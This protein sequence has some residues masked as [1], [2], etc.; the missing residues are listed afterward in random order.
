MDKHKYEIT[1]TG[2]RGAVSGE[3]RKEIIECLPKDAPQGA[4]DL[5][6]VK[7]KETK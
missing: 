5:G 7:E 6:P 4:K 2:G 3:P 1:L